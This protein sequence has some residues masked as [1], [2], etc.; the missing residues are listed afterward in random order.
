M[1]K[2]TPGSGRRVLKCQVKPLWGRAPTHHHPIMKGLRDWRIEFSDEVKQTFN[3]C[4]KLLK[5]SV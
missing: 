4:I 1:G 2:E 3:I 5:L